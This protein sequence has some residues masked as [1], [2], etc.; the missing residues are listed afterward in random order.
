VNNVSD[1][2]TGST[3]IKAEYR[4]RVRKT[5]SDK[6]LI[7]LTDRD[8]RILTWIGEQYAVR[9]DTLQELLGR[10]TRQPTKAD[11]CVSASTARRVVAR[12]KQEGLADARKYFYR[13]PEWVWLTR[14]G[15]MQMNLEYSNWSP[16]VG[17]LKHL[18][19]LNSVRIRI[20]NQFP[21]CRWRSERDLRREHRNDSRFHV[22]DGEVHLNGQVIA[23]EVELTQKSMPRVTE[24]VRQLS[25]QYDRI[26]YFVNG[27]THP[28][29]ERA[30]GDRAEKFRLYEIDRVNR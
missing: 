29:I 11:G 5:R 13:Q 22:A 26:W 9:L 6:G 16:S 28:V 14:K 30:I 21:E 23:V 20:E 25:R 10:E 18:H 1:Y 2:Q 17:I 3:E 7:R 27:Q 19:D 8:L 4:I 24:I 15:L 12:W